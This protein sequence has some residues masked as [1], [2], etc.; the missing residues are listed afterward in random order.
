[1]FNNEL[2]SIVK[3]DFTFDNKAIVN[4]NGTEELW[5]VKYED[6]ILCSNWTED[7]ILSHLFALDPHVEL[8]QKLAK[9]C[10][11][12]IKRNIL[13]DIEML[14]TNDIFEYNY[15]INLFKAE[16]VSE[17]IEAIKIRHAKV[18]VLK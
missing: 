7:D 10:A 6:V 3:I 8:C 15:Y 2:P 14:K 9:E 5:D 17:S 16:K 1:M 13:A 12:E 4:E 18:V 11:A